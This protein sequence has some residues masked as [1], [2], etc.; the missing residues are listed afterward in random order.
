[1]VAE[2]RLEPQVMEQ[3]VRLERVEC[4]RQGD[5]EIAATAQVIGVG[6]EVALEIGLC[7]GAKLG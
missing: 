3:H 7:A 2:F 5:G 4:G 1:M 6:L